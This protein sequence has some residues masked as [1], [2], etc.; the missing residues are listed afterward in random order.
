MCTCWC[1]SISPGHNDL[2]DHLAVG[3]LI[4]TAPLLAVSPIVACSLVESVSKSETK[5]FIG[6]IILC[7]NVLGQNCRK[8]LSQND[9]RELKTKLN[10]HY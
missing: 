9:I 2:W 1:A 8:K 6:Y 3:P 4:A 10:F 7:H 5:W